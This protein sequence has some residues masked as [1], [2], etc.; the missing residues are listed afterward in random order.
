MD[1]EDADDRK[2]LKLLLAARNGERDAL[3]RLLELLRPY[4]QDIA[5]SELGA[6]LQAK[7]GGS[8]LVQQ[9]FLEAN[10]DFANFR[11]SKPEEWRAWLTEIL[12]H[13]LRDLYKYY[14]TSLKRS[15]L[16]EAANADRSLSALTPGPVQTA[17]V[18]EQRQ[19]LEQGLARL[20]EAQREVI[21]LRDEKMTFPEIGK[22][23]KISEEA[24]RM[25]WRRAVSELRRLTP[26]LEDRSEF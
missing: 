13:N 7:V 26:G 4:L 19:L 6:K 9:T 16:R 20:D 15:L 25:Q 12:Q 5:Q 11:G 14:R 1:D 17:I 21:R 18:G 3:G 22:R 24:A 8:D 10:L 23:L 2:F